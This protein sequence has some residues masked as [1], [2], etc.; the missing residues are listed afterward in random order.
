MKRWRRFGI[1]V[2]LVLVVLISVPMAWIA[3]ER[4]RHAH[5]SRLVEELRR[6]NDLVGSMGFP[7]HIPRFEDFLGQEYY[8]LMLHCSSEATDEKLVLKTSQLHGLYGIES[9]YVDS[10]TWDWKPLYQLPD[11]KRLVL[12][13]DPEIFVSNPANLSSLAKF[14][15]LEKFEMLNGWQELGDDHIH[16]K[17]LRKVLPK[18]EIRVSIK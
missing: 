5:C 11:L 9:V 6:T 7:S 18:T 10:R 4:N 14:R 12:D 8:G 2:I 16:V 13:A 15:G 1:R 3:S 17:T